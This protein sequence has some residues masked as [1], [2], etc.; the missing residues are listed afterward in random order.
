MIEF[1]ILKTRR[2]KTCLRG[3]RPSPT[4][5][6]VKLQKNVTGLEFRI[7]GVEGM[8][9]LHNESRDADQLLNHY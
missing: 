8:Y 2:E 5:H 1:Q 3:F 7:Q 6:D 4:K 9:Y